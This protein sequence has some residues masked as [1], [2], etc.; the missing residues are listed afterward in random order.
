MPPQEELPDQRMWLRYYDECS[1]NSEAE[2][3]V[4]EE[5]EGG[6]KYRSCDRD[7]F[8]RHVKPP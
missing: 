8:E 7:L 1:P 2:S 4:K 6:G 5:V 3:G